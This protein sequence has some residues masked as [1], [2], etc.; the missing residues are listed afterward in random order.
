MIH[1]IL[2]PEGW[3]PPLG[4]ANGVEARGRQIFV[5]GMIGWNGQGIFE[6]DDFVGQCRQALSNLIAVLKEAGGGPEHIVRMTWY[7]TS[8]REYLDAGKALGAVYRELMRGADGRVAY[9]A[10]TAVQV[11]ALIE[12]RAK[13]EIEATAVIPD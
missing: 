8:K 1:R 13:V 6:T 9:P 4:Y 7:L 5:A 3:A 10:M 2:Q 11:V 12:D